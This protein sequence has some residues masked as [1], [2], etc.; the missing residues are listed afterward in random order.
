MPLFMTLRAQ[1]GL[2]PFFR[3]I[4]KKMRWCPMMLFCSFLVAYLTNKWQQSR[5]KLF[6]FYIR[7]LYRFAFSKAWNSFA[8]IQTIKRVFRV[9]PCINV[10]THAPTSCTTML[11]WVIWIINF[12]F[13]RGIN[14]EEMSF[15]Q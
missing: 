9:T 1:K 11:A 3:F 8:A 10:V 13:P 2:W 4:S 6:D 7:F 15:L 14:H 5:I 12:I